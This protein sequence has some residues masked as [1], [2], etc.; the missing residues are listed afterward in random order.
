MEVRCLGF[1]RGYHSQATCVAFVLVAEGLQPDGGG[2][3]IIL[4]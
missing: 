1:V 2:G 4:L 3:E